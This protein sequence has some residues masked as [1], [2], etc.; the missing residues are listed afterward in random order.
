[1]VL[2]MPRVRS[3]RQVRPTCEESIQ[4]GLGPQFGTWAEPG[5]RVVYACGGSGAVEGKKRAV[6]TRATARAAGIA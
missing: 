4:A 2:G 5:R 3:A 6:A 1:M